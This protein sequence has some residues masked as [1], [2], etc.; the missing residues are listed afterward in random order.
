MHL[1]SREIREMHGRA[2][3]WAREKEARESSTRKG[4]ASMAIPL[5]DH[6]R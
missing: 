3:T 5:L 1:G 6:R 4:F 2:P